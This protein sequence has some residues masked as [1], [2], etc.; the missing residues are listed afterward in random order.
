[1]VTSVEAFMYFRIFR[2]FWRQRSLFIIII[3]IIKGSGV[4][5]LSAILRGLWLYQFTWN[6]LEFSYVVSFLRA[7]KKCVYWVLQHIC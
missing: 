1:M 2:E 7:C 3:I 4:F 5:S 6:W